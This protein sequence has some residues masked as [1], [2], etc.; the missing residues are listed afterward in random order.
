MLYSEMPV[1]NIK[2]S[3][4][5]NEI[6]ETKNIVAGLYYI[7]ARVHTIQGKE[8]LDMIFRELEE[9]GVLNDKGK[10]KEIY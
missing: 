3:K 1:N 5:F 9:R 6:M 10:S 7:M 4:N 2:V 8:I